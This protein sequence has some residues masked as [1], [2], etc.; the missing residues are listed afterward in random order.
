MFSEKEETKF[1]KTCGKLVKMQ[2]KK[3]ISVRVNV[4]QHFI[5]PSL[6]LVRGNSPTDAGFKNTWEI[7]FSQTL[8]PF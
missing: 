6:S 4:L 5:I 1:V 3:Q 2:K 8:K 7:F